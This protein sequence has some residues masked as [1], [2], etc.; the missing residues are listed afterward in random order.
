[1]NA[2]ADIISV[3]PA[4]TTLGALHPEFA[5]RIAR[6]VKVE[7]PSFSRRM[8]LDMTFACATP[9]VARNSRTM[10]LLRLC[11]AALMIVSGAF[12]LSGEIYS[13]LAGFDAVTFA[14]LELAVGSMLALGLF[15]RFAMFAA[16]AGFGFMSFQSISAGIFDMQSLLCCLTS[17]SFLLLGSGRYSADFLLRKS[18]ILRAAKRR[19]KMQADRLSYKAY[20]LS[21]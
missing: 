12:I 8:W 4:Q 1:M 5:E 2:M 15:T 6:K 11:F 13:P 18:I 7:T 16:V 19:R 20:R 10:L 9:G 21:L 17:L 14:A 3:D